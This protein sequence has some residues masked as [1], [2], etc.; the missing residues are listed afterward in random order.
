MCLLYKLVCKY[1]CPCF[2][3]Q[4]HNSTSLFRE[5]RLPPYLHLKNF[6]SHPITGVM[7]MVTSSESNR[8]K[9]LFVAG[10]LAGILNLWGFFLSIL[11]LC[12]FPS[13]IN[14]QGSGELTGANGF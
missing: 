8:G 10:F 7:N 14:C 9:L 11:I 13:V 5:E 6:E 3:G 12:V 4:H 1:K 2:D